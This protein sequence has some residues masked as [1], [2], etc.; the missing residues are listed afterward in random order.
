MSTRPYELLA[1][2]GNDGTVAG[3]SVR[4]ITTVGDR[5][6]EGGPVP[7]ADATDPAFKQFAELFAADAVAELTELRIERDALTEQLKEAKQ[8]GD[9]LQAEVDRLISRPTASTVTRRQAR[10]AL[11]QA[12]LLDAAEATV[13]Q[14]GRVAEITYESETWNRN[15][16]VLIQLAGVLG[17]TD[18]QLDELFALASTL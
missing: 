10:L 5:D 1:R 11:L 7:L 14:A 16:P 6:Y 3:V 12:D 17:I 15:D 8:R 13:K 2:Y 9:A 4:T 18:E